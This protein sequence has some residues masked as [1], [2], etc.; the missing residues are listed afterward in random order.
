MNGKS[1]I[2]G[3]I[4]IVIIAIYSFFLLTPLFLHNVTNYVLTPI[5]TVQKLSDNVELTLKKWS[6]SRSEKLMTVMFSANNQSLNRIAL[7]W[8]ATER[9]KAKLLNIDIGKQ[10]TTLKSNVKYPFESIVVVEITGVPN[11]FE[12][13]ALTLQLDSLDETAHANKY[14]Y[15]YTNK[16]DVEYVEKIGNPTDTEY[17]IEFLKIQANDKEQGIQ[18]LKEENEKL[19]Q[20]NIEYKSTIQD[21]LTNQDYQTTDEI[22]ASDSRIQSYRKQIS[23]NEDTLSKNKYQIDELEK[24]ISEI[25]Q[26][27]EKQASEREEKPK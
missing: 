26:K 27:I 13:I 19:E 14:V 4:L 12:E 18:K 1:K 21:L 10:T 22:K 8:S 20:E 15:F 6:Y 9:H 11:D 5:N 17:R 24:A 3:I 25:N 23:I 7:N 2:Y 16:N